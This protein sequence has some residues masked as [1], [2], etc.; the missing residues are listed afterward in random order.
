MDKNPLIAKLNK[1]VPGAVLESRRF[2]RSGVTSIWLEAETIAKVAKVLKS[3]ADLKLDWLENLSVVEFE[4][5][6]V[7]TYF[8]A[9]SVTKQS[10]ILRISA[11]PDSLMSRVYLPSTR[12]IW[13]MAE[14]MEKEAE[15]LFGV[16][17]HLGPILRESELKSNLLPE[18][19]VGFPLRKGY[20]FPK[21][22]YGL[23]HSRAEK[24]DLQKKVVPR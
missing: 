17:F 2:G 5:V 3:D 15:E 23:P 7:A 20:V 19:W 1:S 4:N 14:P 11:V 10:L 21:E 6:L 13:P 8:L 9:S 12:A 18:N 16:S 24:K 22:V